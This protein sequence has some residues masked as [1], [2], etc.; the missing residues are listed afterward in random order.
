MR[1]TLLG[2]LIVTCGLTTARTASDASTH[3][4]HAI[5]LMSENPLIDTHIDLPQIIRSLRMFEIKA[6]CS[7]E[8]AILVGAGS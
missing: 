2:S 7:D 3:L 4:D 1:I 5:K 8:V 6:L